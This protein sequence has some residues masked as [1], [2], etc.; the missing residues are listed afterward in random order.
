M[1]EVS[2]VTKQVVYEVE[3]GFERICCL[4]ALHVTADLAFGEGGSPPEGGGSEDTL[5]T[6]CSPWDSSH[7]KSSEIWTDFS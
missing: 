7:R 3:A 1:A 2:P 4:D 6:Y 5:H